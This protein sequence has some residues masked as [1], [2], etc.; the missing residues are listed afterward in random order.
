MLSFKE[1]AYPPWPL[2][3]TWPFD[4]LKIYLLGANG[5]VLGAQTEIKSDFRGWGSPSRDPY[6]AAAKKIEYDLRVQ[7]QGDH[8]EDASR[9]QQGWFEDRLEREE[10]LKRNPRTCEQKALREGK[11][12]SKLR[13]TW[14][15]IWLRQIQGG[16]WP[17]IIKKWKNSGRI[18]WRHLISST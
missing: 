6:E 3:C 8:T 1:E 2:A 14:V 4:W 11:R 15:G 17:W 9:T 5:L 7:T 16:P 18:R 12:A 10:G 13:W